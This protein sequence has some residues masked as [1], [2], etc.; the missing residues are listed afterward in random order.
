MF[1]GGLILW[2]MDVNG[3]YFCVIFGGYG[4]FLCNDGMNVYLLL[5]NK[6][7][8]EGQWNDFC[9]VIWNFEIG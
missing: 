5:M 8:L 1:N 9:L 3:V 4:V 7:D 2:V 6:G